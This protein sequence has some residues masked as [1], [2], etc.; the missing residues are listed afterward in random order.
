MR[1]PEKT[2]PFVLRPTPLAL[3]CAMLIPVMTMGQAAGETFNPALLEKLDSKETDTPDLT[4]FGNGHQPPGTY[5]VTVLLNGIEVDSRMVDFRLAETAEGPKLQPCLSVSDLKEWGVR[6]DRYPQLQAGDASCADLSAVPQALADFDFTNQNLKL[7]LPQAAVSSGVR[8]Y[9][10]PDKWD[11]GLTAAIINYSLS[12]TNNFDRTG[13]GRNSQSQYINLRPGVNLGAWRFRNY[14]T[15]QRSRAGEGRW[16]SAYTYAQRGINALEGQL[17][18]GDSASPSDIFDSVPFRGMQLASDDEM[19]PE[20]QRG[21][22]PVVRGIA[23]GANAEV[24]IRQNGFVIYQSSVPAGPFEISDLYATGGSGDLEVTI[25]ETD[26][27]V[28]RQLVPFAALPVMQR[29]GRLRYSITLGEY[30]PGW[31]GVDDARIA[32]ATAIYGFGLGLTGYAGFQAADHFKAIAAGLGKNM[33]GLGAIS[34]DVTHSS[35][36]SEG[37]DPTSGQSVRLRYSKS[38]ATTGTNVSIA[39]YRY[40]TSGFY[41]LHEVLNSYAPY[42]AYRSTERRRNRAEITLTQRLGDDFGYLSA[43][44]LRED[45]W[46]SGRRLNSWSLGYSNSFK[47]VSY[48]LNYAY[49][50][51]TSGFSGKTASGDQIVSLNL[52]VPLRGSNT[53]AGYNMS[54]RINDSTMHTATLSGTALEGN[55]LNWSVSQG[56]RSRGQEA[57]GAGRAS[58]RGTYGEVNGALSYTPAAQS[59]SA[60]A[61]GALVIHEDGVTFGQKTSETAGLIKA[62]GAAGALLQNYNGVRTDWRG[63][64]VVPYTSP[65]RNNSLA[66]DTGSFA[67]DVEVEK[68]ITGVVPTRGR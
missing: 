8:S 3:L 63:Y 52:S 47:G 41:T 33:A 56:Y 14:S 50:R 37:A 19:L 43:T 65:Y 46:G 48:G 44:A 49:N 60:G 10:S 53:W 54:S 27:S 23:R 20:S 59:I 30:R 61:E 2:L 6:T 7:S 34:A 58:Y 38:L 55:A 12:T 1:L 25:T 32:Q 57:S 64:A 68:A 18:L 35:G 4:A 36:Q 29:E 51:N 26:G 13:Q 11:D 45:Y 40:S 9:V 22:A 31:R 21:Y 62:P 16:E 28:Q 42:S 24:T 5:Q 15:W 66:L 39:G 17:T 67:D